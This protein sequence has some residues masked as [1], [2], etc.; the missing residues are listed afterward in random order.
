MAATI[1]GALLVAAFLVR[2]VLRPA[3]ALAA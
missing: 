2:L 1:A 3:P